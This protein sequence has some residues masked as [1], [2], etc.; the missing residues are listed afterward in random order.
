PRAEALAYLESSKYTLLSRRHLEIGRSFI[1]NQ[2]NG[3]LEQAM[4]AAR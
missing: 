3:A 4:R 1:S 2:N